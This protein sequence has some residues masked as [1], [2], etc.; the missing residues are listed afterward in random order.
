L[1]ELARL[2][3]PELL[4]VQIIDGALFDRRTTKMELL[5]CLAPLAGER[6]VAIAR[7]RVERAREKVRSPQETRLRLMLEDAGIFVDVAIELCDWDGELL[8]EGDL[9]I[10][11]LLIWGEYDGYESHKEQGVFRVDRIG[12][13]ALSRRGWHVMRFVDDDL[14]RREATVR[15]WKQ[16]IAD[17]PARIA[18]MDARRSP[19]VAEARRL[20]GF[21]PPELS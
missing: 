11:K 14:R 7:R 13:R 6:N 5:A 10:Q 17:A 19:E 12:D 20:L 21:D 2:D 9:G 3:L 15:E 1:V 8:A 18:A 16:A 4:V